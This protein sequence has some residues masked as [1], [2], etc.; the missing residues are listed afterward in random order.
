MTETVREHYNVNVACWRDLGGCT[1]FHAVHV[2]VDFSPSGVGLPKCAGGNAGWDSPGSPNLQAFT[3]A[4]EKQFPDLKLEFF[5]CRF[6]EGTQTY[7]QHA[8]WNAIDIMT[9]TVPIGQEVWDWL[10]GPFKPI[11]GIVL[12]DEDAQQLHYSDVT[13]WRIQ[14]QRAK[15]VSDVLAGRPKQKEQ[16]PAYYDQYDKTKAKVG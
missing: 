5:N 16:D 12:T 10:N 11:G 15:A 7:S 6:I 3:S 8:Y 4:V 13:S 14:E 9:P 1:T 2:H